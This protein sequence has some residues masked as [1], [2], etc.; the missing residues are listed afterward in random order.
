MFNALVSQFY[1]VNPH[2]HDLRSQLKST[3]T[4]EHLGETALSETALLQNKKGTKLYS[5]RFVHEGQTYFIRHMKQATMKSGWLTHPCLAITFKNDRTL[6]FDVGERVAS[7]GSGV[8]LSCLNGDAASEGVEEGAQAW[9]A[10]INTLI[11]SLAEEENG[12]SNALVC[13]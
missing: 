8:L 13:P 3:L 9:I 2:N 6:D 10:A 5:D 1:I 12:R 7:S 4:N 11:A